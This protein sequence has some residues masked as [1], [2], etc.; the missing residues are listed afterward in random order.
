MMHHSGRNFR[1][2]SRDDVTLRCFL[3]ECVHHL[4]LSATWWTAEKK[5][6]DPCSIYSMYHPWWQIWVCVCVCVFP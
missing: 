6:D 1:G 2:R 3:D 4:A 5:P